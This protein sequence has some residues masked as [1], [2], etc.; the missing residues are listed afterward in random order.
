MKDAE[1]NRMTMNQLAKEL[2]ISRM[3]LYN[4]MHQKGSYSEETEER[5]QQA[6]EE[7]NFR[8]NNN[9]R[10]L[11]K[12]QEYKIAFVGFYSTRFGYF[13]DKIDSGI[14]DAIA[15]YEDDG[16]KIIKK[17]SDREDPM[18]Q[19]RDLQ[20]LSEAGIKNY[21]IFCYHYEYIEEQI[22]NMIQEGKNVILFSR[23][24]PGI[25]AMCSVGCN[26]FLSGK[27]MAELL[28]KMA[29]EGSSVQLL[30]SEHNHQDKLVVGERLAGFYQAMKNSKKEFCLL[31]NAWTS[32]IPEEEKE[33]ICK[34]IEREKPDVILDFVCNL[35][36]VAEYLKKTGREDTILIGYDVYPEI[37]SHIKDSTIDAV[38]YQNLAS[39][40]YKA[41]QLLFDYVCYGK[42]PKRENYY[43]P[44]NV[45]FANNC[46]YFE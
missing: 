16:L 45:V 12:N 33:Q 10:N 4:I 7:Y 37:V 18:Q 23:R 2:K 38:I 17:Y 42:K 34:V 19:V 29:P 36:C 43:L 8:V 13:F 9:A 44:L 21:I 30:I 28:E 46:E 32:P 24:V 14:E 22:Q 26:D 11:A 3:T 35:E 41:I 1:K 20:E 25:E 6:L 5:V 31:E 15:E 27:L 39:Q 40:S